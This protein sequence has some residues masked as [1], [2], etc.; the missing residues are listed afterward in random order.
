MFSASVALSWAK[1]A[2]RTPGRPS[3]A[4][5]SRPES[6]ASGQH[7]R[8]VRDGAGLLDRVVGERR[9][10]PRRRGAARA[11]RRRRART[12][13]GEPGEQG[14]Q[15]F[16]L[17]RGWS[18]RRPECLAARS[19]RPLALAS[20]A[21]RASGSLHAPSA[22]RSTPARASTARC[23]C[24]EP[25]R[26]RRARGRPSRRSSRRSTGSPS[27]VPWTSTILPVAVATTLRST[28]AFESSR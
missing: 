24:D 10:R 14:A 21:A 17:A 15:L 19:S 4:S 27:A 23:C 8:G 6:S 12:S 16:E 11:G 5:T 28:R 26:C 1:R 13:T 20:R 9:R 22:A 18:W 7:H 2:L 3:S 25:R